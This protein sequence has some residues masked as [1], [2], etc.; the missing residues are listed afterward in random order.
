M[1]EVSRSNGR[2]SGATASASKDLK[3]KAEEVDEEDE[4]EKMQRMEE[5]WKKAQERRGPIV[6]GPRLKVLPEKKAAE[7]FMR[8][9]K[10]NPLAMP[11]PR[12][13]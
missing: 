6:G 5:K 11:P 9:R 13:R 10:A 7:P 4:E 12:R 2:A 3:R 8:P 1:A